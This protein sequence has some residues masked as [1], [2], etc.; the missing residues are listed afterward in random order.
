MP[1]DALVTA[2]TS[3]TITTGVVT[4]PSITTQT[5]TP[6][7]GLSARIAYNTLSAAT[8][9]YTVTVK[10]QKSADNTTFIDAV[11]ADPISFGVTPVA[12]VQD[13]FVHAGAAHPYIRFVVT[14]SP[15]TGTPSGVFKIEIDS[16]IP[17]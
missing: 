4:G 12:G 16:A 14:P 7:R 11:I 8:S 1:A 3:Q 2:L 13:M 5:G 15:T 6:R 10:Q 9:G 17:G